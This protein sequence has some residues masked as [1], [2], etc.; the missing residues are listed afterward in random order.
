[1]NLDLIFQFTFNESYIQRIG[2]RNQLE[3]IIQIVKCYYDLR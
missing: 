1:M 3:I 2:A